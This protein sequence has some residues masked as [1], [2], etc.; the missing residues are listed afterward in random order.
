MDVS[1]IVPGDIATQLQRRHHVPV[2]H[3]PIGEERRPDS[4]FAQRLL[5]LKLDSLSQ[6]N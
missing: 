1:R 2:H 6:R 5:E 4:R 3:F